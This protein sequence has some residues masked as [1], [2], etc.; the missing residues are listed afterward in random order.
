ME[1]VQSK[2]L[3]KDMTLTSM[4]MAIGILLPSIFHAFHLGGPV[5]LPMHIPV[6]LCGFLVGRKYGL[7]CG[8]TVPLLSSMLTGMP[9]LFPV[10]FTMAIELGTYGYLT[11]LL[12]RKINVYLA[13]VSAQ[14]MGRIIGGIGSFVL[15]GLAGRPFILSTYMTGVFVTALPGILLQLVLIPI[16]ILMLRRR[17]AME[18]HE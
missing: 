11:G 3:A 9:P 15:L 4:F 7:I 18:K 6:I 16:G 8:L 13:L 5:F 17:G 1:K 2:A 12:G 14:V 10:A